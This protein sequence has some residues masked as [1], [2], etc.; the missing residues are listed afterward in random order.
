M[1]DAAM[2][3]PVDA[4]DLHVMTYN[5]RRRMAHV[6]RRS[7]D[8]WARRRPLLR[9]LLTREKPTILGIQEGLPDQVDF[10]THLLGPGYARVGRGRNA[11]GD[12]EQCTL[13]YD[14]ARLELND[15]T[16]RS[17][18]DS[19][20]I[21]GSRSWGN[22][23]PRIVVS[24]DFTDLA[25]GIRFSVFNTHFDHL[26]RTSRARSAGMVNDLVEGLGT[27]AIVLGDMNSGVRSLPY[28][29]LTAGP[30][31]DAWAVARRRLTPAWGTYSGYRKPKVGG[32][33]IDWML[34][35]DSASVEEIGI[36]TARFDG[37]A[38]SDHE[39][40]QARLRF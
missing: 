8:Q 39:P 18:S 24:A 15:W 34:V 31:R 30:L 35:T 5:I 1:T 10:L 4:P 3:G 36:N 14:S 17:L 22:M 9:I 12:G 38:P 21:A 16:Q 6:P 13:F 32:K 25:T 33:R 19:P 20:A 37:A 40:V 11:D 27:P 26:S 29:L 2:I 7:P 23:L 28:R